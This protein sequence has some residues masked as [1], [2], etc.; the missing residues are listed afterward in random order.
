MCSPRQRCRA[1][2]EVSPKATTDP[3]FG[4]IDVPTAAYTAFP[5]TATPPKLGE[6][7]GSCASGR[8]VAA[9]RAVTTPLKSAM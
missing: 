6:P 4:L 1:V 9:S 2:V 7:I 5:T 8:P 3:P